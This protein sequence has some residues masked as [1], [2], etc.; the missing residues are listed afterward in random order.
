VDI[1]A[2]GRQNVE[3]KHRRSGPY[4]LDK[5]VFRDEVSVEALIIAAERI[6]PTYQPATGR[7]VRLVTVNSEEPI[8][9]DRDGDPEW[10]YT[11]I[12]EGDNV[13]SL[14]ELFNAFP[15]RPHQ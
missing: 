3:E 1:T 9:W 12:T 10:E 13:D 15:G 4:S 7:W 11:V 5:S 6:A 8:G 2:L 14:H